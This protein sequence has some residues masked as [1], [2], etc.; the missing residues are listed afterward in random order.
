MILALSRFRVKNGMEGAVREAFA[1][2]PR[3]VEGA[4]GFLGLEVYTET[5]APAG[6]VLVTRWRDEAS[7]R[8]WHDGPDR[9][10]SHGLIPLGLKLDPV[11]TSLVIAE[12]ID[13]ATSGGTL[14]N[15]LLDLAAP[16]GRLIQGSAWLHLVEVDADGVV[17]AANAAATA[18]AGRPI[19]GLPV[20]ALVVDTSVGALREALANPPAGA[21]LIHFRDARDNPATLRCTV[22]AG[23]AGH[24]LLGEPTWDHQR[25]YVGE[26]EALNA[27]LAILA[28]ENARRGH[29]LERAHAELE[30]AHR[31][32][33]DS[34]WHLR[35][36]ASVLPM[37]VGC[38][39]V[40]TETNSWEEVAT[41]LTRNS[42]FLSHVYCLTCAEAINA[43]LDA[44]PGDP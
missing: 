3:Q 42:T 6:F 18:L 5:A 1:Q 4:T 37:C 19:V 9:D 44:D 33:R 14:G 22:E 20:E 12:R 34:H 11:G 25:D 17:V 26:L 31:E 36:A 21:T 41:F 29:A 27:E 23:V 16:I 30:A 40:Q 7:Y 10:A 28:R 32:L 43:E 8:A 15:T 2:R 35:K 39:R 24:T 13:A 38:R